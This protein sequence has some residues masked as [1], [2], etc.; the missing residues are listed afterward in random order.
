MKQIVDR[1]VPRELDRRLAESGGYAVTM[2]ARELVHHIA[3]KYS[4][5]FCAL[6]NAVRDSYLRR[7]SRRRLKGRGGKKNMITDRA[8]VTVRPEGKR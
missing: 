3:R 5:C 1:E 8:G 2:D 7:V 6:T 4:L